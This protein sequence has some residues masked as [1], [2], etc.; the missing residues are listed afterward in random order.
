MFC[1]F[2][3]RRLLIKNTYICRAAL[4]SPNFIVNNYKKMKKTFILALLSL[5]ALNL[6]AEQKPESKNNFKFY[7]FVR[8]YFVYDSR[9]SLAGTGDLFYYIPLDENIVNGV[10]LHRNNTFTFLSITSRLGV[11]VTGYQYGR[12]HFG[13]KIETDFYYGLS[14]A[15]TLDG[16]PRSTSVTGTAALRLRQAYATIAWKD[17]PLNKKEKAEVLLKIGQAWHPLSVDF[18]HVFTLE[19][20]VPF[21]PFSRTPQVRMDASLG[22]NWIISAAGVWQM[23]Y[24]SSGP[25]GAVADYIKYSCVP[26]IYTSISFKSKG[27]LARLG[28]DMLSIKPRVI[29]KHPDAGNDIKVSDRIT[30]F[31]P[32]F[33]AHYDYKKFSVRAKTF[34]AAAGEHVNLMGGYAKIDENPDGSWNYAP[35]HNS[36]SWL[37]LSYGKKFQSVLYLGYIQ[38]L[39]LTNAEYGAESKI[40]FNRNG[41]PH[42]KRIARINP[43]FVLTLGKLQLGLEYQLSGA[44]YG[45]EDTLDTKAL[46]IATDLHWVWNN[47]VQVMVKFNF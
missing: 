3:I 15:K 44:E 28:V 14:N 42:I 27:F 24:V 18:P 7:G 29:G 36:T 34:Y 32:Y 43:Q 39:G 30:T 16:L 6:S 38:N 12:A 46:P 37:S 11:D 19:T 21:N 8:N 26:E 13:A 45:K 20:G 31:T 35:L 1:S 47:R 17:L 4:G 10:D 25:S 23:Q 2:E 40:Y 22:K 9:E 33:Y 41:F 5:S